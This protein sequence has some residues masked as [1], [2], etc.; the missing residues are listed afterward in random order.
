MMR[1]I[2]AFLAVLGLLLPLSVPA[3]SADLPAA[4]GEA[5][6]KPVLKTEF[7]FAAKTA[8]IFSTTGSD[9]K[10]DLE[11]RNE[12]WKHLTFLREAEKRGV[13]VAPEEVRAELGRLLAEKGIQY[14]SYNYHEFLKQNFG[15][16]STTFEKRIENLLKVKKMLDGIM[17]PPKPTIT[18]ADAKQKFL[19]QYNSMNSEF[20][21][22]PTLEEA[23]A[24]YKKTSGKKWD[25]MKRK[26]VKSATP[27]GHI[28]LEALIDLWQVP[29][30]DA[31]RIHALAVG[32]I[33]AP[34]KMYKGYGVFRVLEK[35]NAD[36]KEYNDKKK[37]EYKK[38][39][40][41]V[42]YYNNT[43]KVVQDIVKE[44]ALRDY[45]RDK[46]AVVETT[47]GTFELQLYPAVAP[48]AVE[49]FMKLA[50]KKY[51]DGLIFHRVIKGF[52]IQGGDPTG[53]G[54]GGESIWGAPFED[55][56]NKD[57]QF[58]R[59][60]LLAMANSGPA[61]NGSQFFVTLAPTPHLNMKHTI[62]GEV[63]TGFE[64]VRKIGETPTDP[65]DRPLSEQKIVR[66]TMKKWPTSLTFS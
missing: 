13:T 54:S 66:L 40:E 56:V 9:P 36:P 16:D 65:G 14:G 4:V 30:A 15:E 11:R 27:T 48:K 57:V 50:E 47:Q 5:F 21:N 49:N 53:T 26:D 17:N 44:A 31:Y 24:F 1:K 42:Y 33:G 6:G 35:K 18:D 55:E 41:Q 62:F 34:A 7:D 25:E 64:N 37:E 52:M 60:G 32:K 39:L 43:Q 22:F 38:V 19:N 12:T 45:E 8:T 2:T 58:D 59:A 10:D 3:S 20:V 51:Y 61:T 46:V 28:S 63:I 29:T 23:Q